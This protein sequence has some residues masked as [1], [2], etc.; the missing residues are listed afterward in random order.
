VTDHSETTGKLLK[1]KNPPQS[2]YFNSP[3]LHLFPEISLSGPVYTWYQK[4]LIDPS[5]SGRHK[6]MEPCIHYRIIKKVFV[7]FYLVLNEPS[8]N[9]SF[10]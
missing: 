10:E 1:Q 7:T 2:N 6:I 5:T 8:K 9:L 4:E 3:F